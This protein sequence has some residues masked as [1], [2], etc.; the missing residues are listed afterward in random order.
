MT[1]GTIVCSLAAGK[2]KKTLIA[3]RLG[4]WEKIEGLN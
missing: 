4:G 1:S 3:H 2:K